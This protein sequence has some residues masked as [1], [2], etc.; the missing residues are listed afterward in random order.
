MTRLFTK[1]SVKRLASAWLEY[2]YAWR[3]LWFDIVSFSEALEDNRRKAGQSFSERVGTN[4]SFNEDFTDP[5]TS[6]AF[7]GEMVTSRS[8][9]CGVRGGVS[10]LLSS[11]QPN[12]GANPLTTAWELVQFSFVVDWF[13]SV[14]TYLE[15]LSI[16][17]VALQA[18]YYQGTQI[19]FKETKTL[20]VEP[21][22]PL[23]NGDDVTTV[24]GSETLNQLR[25]FTLKTR[26]PCGLPSSPLMQNRLDFPKV[27]DLA[28]IMTKMLK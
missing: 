14:G 7:I 4:L 6:Y 24:T 21:A 3:T 25:E 13:I 23:W 16:S 1:F 27:L 18:Q 9:E 22:P 20:V 8:W 2:R 11:D 26:T 15:T 19:T 17:D 28:A 12:Y 10:G 5:Y